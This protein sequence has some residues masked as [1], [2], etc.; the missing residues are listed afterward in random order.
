M[1]VYQ[2][3]VFLEVA[4]YLSFTEAADTLNLTQPAV[5]AKIKSLE[6]EIGTS[7]FHRLGRKVQLT[8]VGQ[9]LFTEGQK[10]IDLE[11]HLLKTIE[12]IKQGKLGQLKVGCTTAIAEHWLPEVLF[13]YRQ[14]YPDIQT[15]CV[16][17]DSAESLHRA[18]TS[19]QIDLGVSEIDLGDFAEISATA[20]APIHYAL[21]VATNHPLTKQKWLSLKE[22]QKQRWVV[23][24]ASS[25]NRLVLES[26]LTELGRSLADFP[27]I[28][29]VDTLSLVRTYLTQGNYVGFASDL[30]FKSERQSRILTSIPLQEFPL[31]GNVF[32]LLPQRLSQ[33]VIP[34]SDRPSR[35]SP[36][37]N[38]I[39]K[40][41]ALVQPAQTSTSELTAASPATEPSVRLRS[42]SLITRSHQTHHPETIT[43]RIGIQNATIPTVTGGLVIQRLGLLEHFLPR[44]G[45]YSSTQYQIQWQD[46]SLGAPIIQGLQSG[47][48]DIGLLGDYPSLLS[49][50]SPL[51]SPH[52]VSKT[53]LVSFVSANPDGSCNA[54]IVPHESKLQSVEDL[55]GRVIAVPFSSSAHGMVMRSLQAANLLSDVTIAALDQANLNRPFQ[56]PT[57]LADGY[58]HFAPFHAIACQQGKFRYLLDDDLSGLPAF[59]AVVVSEV[60]AE[61]HPE[62]VIAYLKALQAAQ[63]WC[64]NT[65]AALPLISRWTQLDAEI[66]VQLL[67]S[68]F[69]KQQPGRFFSEMTIRPDWIAQHI[70]QLSLI[71]GNESLKAIDLNQWVQ[72]D[73]LQTAKARL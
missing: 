30:E 11:N 33:S 24:P 38:P 26:R 69:Q 8:E 50:T 46:F 28:E 55:R 40:F 23:L 20:I 54:V 49:A 14:Q 61:R 73:L 47:Q 43:I 22:L 3:R 60:L 72:P 36:S 51:D 1:E 48:L 25:A 13:R 68:T 15:Q 10:L 70:A 19:N 37:L 63:Y 34:P 64:A 62:I 39:Q 32:L 58:A 66:I 59:H 44:S 27:Q 35:K 53:R 18:L 67:S 71:P 41:A 12:E 31:P 6:S 4:R 9:F 7:L 21:I 65:S 2:V 17:F 57:K 42:P 45:R 52:P 16:V 56:H 29:T 5:S